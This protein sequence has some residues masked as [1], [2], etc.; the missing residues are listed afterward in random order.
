MPLELGLPLTSDLLARP[1]LA[2]ESA[3]ESRE[4]RCLTG[5][6]RPQE[7]EA[8]TAKTESAGRPS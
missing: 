7:A 3:D 4:D 8:S 1:M 5:R 2:T 6:A